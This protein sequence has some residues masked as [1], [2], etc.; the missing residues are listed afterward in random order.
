M[1]DLLSELCRV[2]CIIRADYPQDASRSLV[3]DLV[4]YGLRLEGIEY[5]D[6]E[7]AA[8]IAEQIA[9]GKI[10]MDTT[11]Q[12][13]D[14]EMYNSEISAAI[15]EFKKARIKIARDKKKKDSEAMCP[16]CN[17]IQMTRRCC[18]VCGTVISE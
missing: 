10:T 16:S 3:H 12:L 4:M 14:N 17:R 5:Q 13:D 6:R 11:K 1:S 15:A 7:E 2:Y 18:D 8:K 9:R